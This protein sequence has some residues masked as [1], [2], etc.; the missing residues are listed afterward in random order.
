LLQTDT[1]FIPEAQPPLAGNT[2]SCFSIGKDIAKT[3]WAEY[4]I[5]AAGKSSVESIWEI[6]TSIVPC[7]Q[8]GTQHSVTNNTALSKYSAGVSHCRSTAFKTT[9]LMYVVWQTG[10]SFSVEDHSKV[11]TSSSTDTLPGTGTLAQG[12]ACLLHCKAPP[13]CFPPEVYHPNIDPLL[14]SQGLT[15]LQVSLVRQGG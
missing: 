12:D 3:L 10:P 14:S 13:H 15:R 9:T 4:G 11:G 2:S 7:L 5:A 6:P 1:G 8:T